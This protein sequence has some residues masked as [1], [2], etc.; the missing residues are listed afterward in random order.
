MDY[1]LEVQLQT[2]KNTN[3]KTALWNFH[4]EQK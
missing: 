2:S 1:T 4:L 3:F